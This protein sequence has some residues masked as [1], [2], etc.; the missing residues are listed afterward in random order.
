MF[1]QVLRPF[2]GLKM[3]KYASNKPFVSLMCS[4]QCLTS[5]FPNPR[6]QAACNVNDHHFWSQVSEILKVDKPF[7]GI[8]VILSG[9]F[10]QLPPVQATAMA[11]ESSVWQELQLKHIALQQNFR[12][13]LMLAGMVGKPN[14][15]KWCLSLFWW[16]YA[17]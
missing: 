3:F 10:L 16:M 17:L 9:D 12:G 4:F 15:S 14:E 13:L 7:G 11:F 5:M 8:Q 2:F 6:V 1:P